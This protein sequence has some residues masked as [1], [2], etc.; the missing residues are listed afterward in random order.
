MGGEGNAA[1][2]LS[3]LDELQTSNEWKRYFT[4][5]DFPYGFYGIEKYKRL[6]DESGFSINRVELIQKDMEHDGKSGLEG[7][8][9]TTWLPY[10]ERIPN[11]ESL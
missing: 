5:F 4:D 2:I 3:I 7:W 11:P 8:I 9:R 6:L 1:V 10:V